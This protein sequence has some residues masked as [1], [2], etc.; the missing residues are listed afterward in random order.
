M[1]LNPLNCGGSI[2]IKVFTHNLLIYFNRFFILL[3]TK[4]SV[5][6]SGL[7]TQSWA[8]Q[9]TNI[10]SYVLFTL[11]VKQTR[12][13][14]L[15][16]NLAE[17]HS[18]SGHH[19]NTLFTQFLVFITLNNFYPNFKFILGSWNPL[20]TSFHTTFKARTGSVFNLFFLIDKL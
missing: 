19:Q 2:T 5:L 14:L 8:C 15:S 16:D 1:V 4:L 11:I 6:H 9:D 18:T 20:A 12:Q 10:T 13:C 7:L 3:D 17:S